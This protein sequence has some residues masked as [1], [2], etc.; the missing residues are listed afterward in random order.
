[1]DVKE[2]KEKKEKMEANIA[3]A[4]NLFQEQTGVPIAAVMVEPRCRVRTK[5]GPENI[6]MVQV[7]LDI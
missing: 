6:W 3:V 7:A 4:L 5:D 1:M 2:L